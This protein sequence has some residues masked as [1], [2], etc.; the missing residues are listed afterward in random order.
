MSI[1]VILEFIKTYF[2]HKQPSDFWVLQ[3]FCRKKMYIEKRMLEMMYPFFIFIS[4]LYAP[5]GFHVC[6][7]SYHFTASK[8][9][10]DVPLNSV[11]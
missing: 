4:Y 9:K 8:F 7:Y 5:L 11:F 1:D 3:Q 6:F 10:F 2:Y